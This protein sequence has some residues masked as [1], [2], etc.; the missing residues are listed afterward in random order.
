[1]FTHACMQVRL[2]VCVHALPRTLL[3]LFGHKVPVIETLL[4]NASEYFCVFGVESVKIGL[5]S[6]FI[7]KQCY[8]GASDFSF[9]L[10]LTCAEVARVHRKKLRCSALRDTTAA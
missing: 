6:T 2:Y 1:M 7:K 8:F 5:L 3:Q 9:G 4:H 10:G